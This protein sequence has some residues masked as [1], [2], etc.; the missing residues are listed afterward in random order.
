MKVL[1]EGFVRKPEFLIDIIKKSDS[2]I[3][4]FLLQKEFFV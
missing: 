2:E 1:S 4:I 3:Q